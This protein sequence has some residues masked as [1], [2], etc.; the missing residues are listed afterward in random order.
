MTGNSAL[1]V[2]YN[3]QSQ[4]RQGTC[5]LIMFDYSTKMTE[6]AVLEKLG[7]TSPDR[8]DSSTRQLPC[9]RT[10]SQVAV[11]GKT[12]KTSPGTKRLDDT[13]LQSE[14]WVEKHR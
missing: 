7:V 1:D 6:H 9:N 2:C 14:D 3:R 8:L 10:M 12:T 11:P 13:A 4:S 5:A